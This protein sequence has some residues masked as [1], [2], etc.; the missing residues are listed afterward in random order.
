MHKKQNAI[1][2][3]RGKYGPKGLSLETTAELAA[4]IG[5]AG[6]E[7]LSGGLAQGLTLEILDAAQHALLYGNKV[8]GR[9]L[10]ST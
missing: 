1:Q 5:S 2:H 10:V 9:N 8:V 4:G 6:A 7:N 3:C